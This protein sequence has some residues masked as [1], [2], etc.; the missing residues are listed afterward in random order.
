[1]EETID[2]IEYVLLGEGFRVAVAGP[3]FLEH[4]VGNA[5]PPDIF[6][7]VNIVE[8][9]ALRILVFFIPIEWEALGFSF[10]QQES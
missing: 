8:E 9:R 1:M 3:E 7:V 4:P 5:V 10:F 6:T 2:I